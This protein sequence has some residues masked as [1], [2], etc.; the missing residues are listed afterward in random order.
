M[1]RK[2][3]K[4]IRRTVLAILAALLAFVLMYFP[5]KQNVWLAVLVAAA[6]YL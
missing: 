1:D 5:A 6:V 3:K 2:V 4:E